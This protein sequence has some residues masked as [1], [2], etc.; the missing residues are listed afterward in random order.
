[1][2]QFLKLFVINKLNHWDS[3]ELSYAFHSDLEKK[4]NY[5][6]SG[7]TVSWLEAREQELNQ[8]GFSMAWNKEAELIHAVPTD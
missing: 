1:M 5:V 2:S 8:L 6:F 4:G 7:E 3:T